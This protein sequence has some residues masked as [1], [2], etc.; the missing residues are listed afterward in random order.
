MEMVAGSCSYL[1]L[2]VPACGAAT[3]IDFELAIVTSAA[4]KSLS[5]PLVA[6]RLQTP[7]AEAKANRDAVGIE[8]TKRPERRTAGVGPKLETL[9]AICVW[10]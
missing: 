5:S 6:S 4:A 3:R 1:Y 9:E 10:I 7:A 2:L 8:R